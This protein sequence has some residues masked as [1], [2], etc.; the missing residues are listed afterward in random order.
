MVQNSARHPP[1]TAASPRSNRSAAGLTLRHITHLI[2]SV[3]LPSK[4]WF[5]PLDAQVSQTGPASLL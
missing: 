5:S 2:T 3:R 4:V 1:Q